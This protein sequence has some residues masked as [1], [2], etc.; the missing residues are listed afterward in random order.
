MGALRGLVFE[1][2]ERD[3]LIGRTQQL[4]DAGARRALEQIVLQHDDVTG[5][6]APQRR[7]G[8]LDALAAKQRQPK[9]VGLRRDQRDP[10]IA[11]KRSRDRGCGLHRIGKAE[12]GACDDQRPLGRLQR[13]GDVAGV[14]IFIATRERSGDRVAERG[15]LQRVAAQ[16]QRRDR[17]ERRVR[18]RRRQHDRA[19]AAFAGDAHR[20]IEPLMDALL[21]R[22]FTLGTA[23]GLAQRQRH[24]RRAVGELFA[25][26][27]HGVAAFDLG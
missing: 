10:G 16:R 9:T 24:A 27:Q 25:E 2:I 23:R 11:A 1:M 18:Q 7:G 13:A 19:A 14:A 8:R 5:W 21:R 6:P 12:P 20:L 17:I 15:D 3:H 26:H 4:F 22:E